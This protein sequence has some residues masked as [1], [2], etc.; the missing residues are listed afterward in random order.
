MEDSTPKLITE[1]QFNESVRNWT[2]PIRSRM[3][4]NAQTKTQ[5]KGKGTSYSN[6]KT[7]VREVPLASSVKYSVL[8]KYGVASRVRFSF[9]RQGVYLHY[10]V[11]RGYIRSGNSIQRGFKNQPKN[12]KAYGSFKRT[13]VDWFDV[14]IRMGINK[15]ADIV[16]EFYGDEAMREILDQYDKALIEKKL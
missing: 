11:G 1:D 12:P 9:P 2:I 16:Q 8:K 4:M 14:E 7:R 6:I 13:P 10:G 5:G 3:V 15:L